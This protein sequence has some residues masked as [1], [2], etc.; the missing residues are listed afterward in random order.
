M[1]YGKKSCTKKIWHDMLINL[2]GVLRI[3]CQSLFEMLKFRFKKKAVFVS[4]LD[5]GQFYRI[6]VHLLCFV[7]KCF[8]IGVYI[9]IFY[10]LFGAYLNEIRWCLEI[11]SALKKNIQR[12]EKFFSVR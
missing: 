11:N 4:C 9:Y 7:K 12:T 5:I 8:Y 3:C 2:F 10:V 6:P 1:K